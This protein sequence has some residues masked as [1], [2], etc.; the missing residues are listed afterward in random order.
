MPTAD[1]DRAD[2]RILE[3][4]QR[5][6]RI[7]N[8]E[9]AQRVA[10][11]PSPCLRRLGRLEDT[12][13]I[14]QYVALVEP[15]RVGLG[16]I[17]HLEVMLDKRAEQAR[18]TFRQSV[19]GWPEVLTC[20]ALTGQW[21][22]LLKV[23]TQDLEHYSRFLMEKVLALPVVVNVQSSFVLEKVKESTALPLHHLQQA[24]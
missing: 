3:I 13:V 2:L 11:S 14:A 16:M 17:A 7:A 20:Y 9:L 22:Y 12:G 4:I 10:L 6:G 21:D 8:V 15:S 5:E 19:L 18:A 1:L 23:I 24:L